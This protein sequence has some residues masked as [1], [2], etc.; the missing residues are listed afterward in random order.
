MVI[1]R[2][3]Y[4]CFLL[5]ASFFIFLFQSCTYEKADVD[6]EHT[7]YPLT[8]ENII[9][10]KCATTGCHNNESYLSSSGLNL[11]SWDKMF[12]GNTGGAVAIPFRP[13]FST[14]CY[15]TNTDSSK[16]LVLMPTMPS[17]QP[18]LS[19]AEY[20][21]L[22]SWIEQ[23]APDINGV[24][25]FS[26]SPDRLKL[27]VG[28]Q[29]Q[30]EVAVLDI[31]SGLLMRYIH[32]GTASGDFVHFIKVSPDN[33]YWYA[34]LS[35]GTGVQKFRTSDNS[36]VGNISLPQKAWNTMT[37]SS[38]SK[39]GY[40]V[41]LNVPGSV[42][43]V[44][45]ESLAVIDTW[46]NFEYPHGGAL[47]KNNDTLYLTAQTGNFIY[48][49][50]V[51]DHNNFSY[52]VIDSATSTWSTNPA[53]NP[54]EIL[55][56]N[57]YSKYYITCQNSDDVRVIRTSDDKLLSIIPTPEFPARMSISKT[58]PYLFVTCMSTVNDSS[59]VTGRVY[60]IDTNNDAIVSSVMTGHQPHGIAVSDEKNLVYVVNRNLSHGG[61]VSHHSSG[62]TQNGYIV[63][64]DMNTLQLTD[65][66]C[67]VAKDPYS[68]DIS[69]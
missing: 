53:M 39:R 61:P 27:Y 3:Q 16:G 43:V 5:S 50:P 63:S 23:G 68:S 8:V 58:H 56:S 45:L 25:K 4:F 30:N 19:S 28:N 62:G 6:I 60:V 34:V 17:D 49:I 29:L 51:N 41:E 32:V 15:F 40:V 20:E 10:N 55:F 54:H 47:S 31:Q 7:G 14:L 57:D 44:D 12:E 37:I 65:F 11:V 38:D 48:K 42:A 26:D 18:P 46:N 67:E 66:K 22:R 9:V 36:L 1:A 2:K 69:K 35:N 24:V 13:D 59:S 21:I 64:I 52:V 33:K